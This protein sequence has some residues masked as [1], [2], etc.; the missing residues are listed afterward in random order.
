MRLAAQLKDGG[1]RLLPERKV[2]KAAEVTAVREARALIDDAAAEA[3]RIRQ[4]A[5]EAYEQEKR[6]GYQDGLAAGGDEVAK[7]LIE[8]AA[9]GSELMNDFESRVP[10]IV[11][12]A[13][14]QILG[15]FD[16]TEL[17]IRTANQALRMFHKQTE[18]VVRVPPDRLEKV[19]ARIDELRSNGSATPDIDVVAD[20]DLT[21]GGCVIE[22]ELGSV[23]A[24]IE[25]QLAVLEQAM[26][27]DLAG[28][29]SGAA[30]NAN[31]QAG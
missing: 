2:V 24:S 12:S 20:R 4:A 9:Q 28:Q 14:R 16:D 27:K 3:E 1:L 5:K 30:P 23:D 22:S 17:A 31:G 7:R 13:L 18:L 25:A 10:E 8:L 19:R 26:R 11:I 15:T 21:D 29:T 6:R